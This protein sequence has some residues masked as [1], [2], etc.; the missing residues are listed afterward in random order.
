MARFY[1]RAEQR[2]Y[3]EKRR[4]QAALVADRLMG[5]KKVDPDVI[6]FFGGTQMISPIR[7]TGY[8]KML[9]NIPR[10]SSIICNVEGV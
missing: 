6:D 5:K 3:R 7:Y 2:A 8:G 10:I 9:N 1:T 4:V